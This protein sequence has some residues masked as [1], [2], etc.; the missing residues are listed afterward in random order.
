M[1]ECNQ[2]K[3][4]FISSNVHEL[5]FSS[6]FSPSLST[7]TLTFFLTSISLVFLLSYGE[8]DRKFLGEQREKEKEREEKK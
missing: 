4:P 7:F 8:K 5:S 3:S 6:S 1:M 2:G